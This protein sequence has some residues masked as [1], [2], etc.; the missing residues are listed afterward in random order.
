MNFIPTQPEKAQDVPYYEDVTSQDGWQGQDTTKSMETL[1]SEVVQAISR[2]GGLVVGFQRGKF[3]TEVGARE[4]FR[5]HY[6]I[7][8][9]NGKMVAG[10]IDIAALPIK[11]DISYRRTSE[12]RQ[13]RS[14]KMALYMFRNSMKGVWFL[15]QLSP[16]YSALMPWM[17]VDGKEGKTISQLWSESTV[18]KNLLP[19]GESEFVDGKYTVSAKEGE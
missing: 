16:G 1:K 18:M 12:Q 6:S 4:G 15:Q 5:I 11:S 17:L 8:A 10:R 13:E 2:L 9:S 19:P 7:E 14:L 3:E